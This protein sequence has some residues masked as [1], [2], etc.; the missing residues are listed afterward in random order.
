MKRPTDYEIELGEIERDISRLAE[1]TDPV[2]PDAATA[3][4]YAYLLYHRASLT[5]NPREFETA[6]TAIDDAISQ[7]GP[8]PDLCL[9]K[10]H[11]DF[12]LHRL[13]AARED[14]EMARGL[15][16]F[17]QG[18]ALKAD[19]DLQEGRYEQARKG[20]ES[21]IEDDPTW[22]NLARLA[23]FKAKMGD[24]EGAERLYIEAEEEI[25]AKQ[26]RSYAWVELQRGLLDLAHGRFDG[27]RA[28]YERAGEAY[29]GYWL[30]DE[31]IA[32]LLGA[33]GRYAEAAALY[34]EVVARVPR[35]DLQQALGDV[36]AS[37]DDADKARSWH[38]RA[39]A[40]YLESA[41]CGDVRYLHHLAEFY[42]E[43]RE[44]GAEAVKWASKDLALRPNYSTRAALAWAL[45]RDGQL[46][47]ALGLMHTALSSGVRDARLF[48]Q[49]AEIH[50]A[51]G[52][53]EEGRRY[54]REA[55]GINPHYQD[56]HAHL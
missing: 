53:A 6:Q 18:R 33:Q 34:E 52:R 35:P 3:T 32:R 39:L 24:V 27:A 4:R 22:D 43:V 54:L 38:E 44:D 29:S 5:E 10:A 25:T 45:Y 55:A 13:A 1:R 31:H 51:S 17:P 40:A 20:Y 37:M 12:K 2:P 21:V 7:V 8:W 47:G 48:A 28:H 26:M 41:E 56:V 46:A 49:A 15:V 23:Y 16:G 36:Y 50:R 30:I 42:S 11:L 14:L 19:L 9:L